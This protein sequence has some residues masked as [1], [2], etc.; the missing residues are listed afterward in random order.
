MKYKLRE[1]ENK[2]TDWKVVSIIGVDGES[3]ESVSVNRVN[4]KGEVFPNF[5]GI[6]VG[7]EVEG[8]LWASDA[9]K[10]YLFAPKAFTKG[11]GGGIA[12]AQAVKAEYIKEA[13]A[14]KDN[15][16]AYFNATNSAI[17]IVNSIFAN[18]DEKPTRDTL[19]IQIVS[20]RDWFLSEWDAFNSGTNA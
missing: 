19:E 17:A 18:T 16:I 14:R 13:Q 10:K 6:V 11:S 3:A 4:K 5:D 12:K 9:G 1:V 15:S 20:W 2:G 7:G 8:N